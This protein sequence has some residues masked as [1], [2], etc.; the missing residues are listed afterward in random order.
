MIRVQKNKKYIKMKKIAL[1][2]VLGIMVVATSC[3]KDDEWLNQ[4]KTEVSCEK[5]Q[6]PKADTVRVNDTVTVVMRDTLV[7]TV[8]LP[9]DTVVVNDTV[10]ISNVD[11]LFITN[12]VVDT[13][14]ITVRD[15]VTVTNTEIVNDTLIVTETVTINDT[16]WVPQTVVVNDTIWKDNYILQTD[17][18]T[19]TNTVTETV[20][21]TVTVTNTVTE[22]VHDTVT[23][24]N[25]VTETVRDTVTVTNTV[26]ETVRDTVTIT[27]TETVTDTVYVP[28]TQTEVVVKTVHDTV[29]V[30]NNVTET[31]HDTV[32]V[33]NTVT[34]TIHD[35]V[36]VNKPEDV[37]AI[38]LVQTVA[39][40]ANKKS[41]FYTLIVRYSD[42]TMLPMV[43]DREGNVTTFDKVA[44]DDRV[45][46]LS[47]N[48][49]GEWVLTK[50][51]DS[52]ENITYV[53]VDGKM[54]CQMSYTLAEQI[55]WDEGHQNGIANNGTTYC[56]VK[57]FRYTLNEDGSLTDNYTKSTIAF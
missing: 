28:Q 29:T 52:A 53:T 31:V 41:Y 46:G 35:T 22:T 36:Y 16:V 1:A 10:I 19:V 55:G 56:S 14:T 37:K 49:S 57:T 44:N 23:V 43:I 30:T 38:S 26:T 4:I 17:T 51:E 24:T 20:H 5:K 7:N 18:V 33:T 39:P 45:N 50:A 32:T 42:N 34:D 11:T 6:A 21:D 8:I 27:N 13:V 3:E 47:L 54:N 2:L 48:R 15:T 40:S 25:T 9:Q 12:N